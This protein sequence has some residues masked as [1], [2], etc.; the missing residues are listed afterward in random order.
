MPE[1]GDSVLIPIRFTDLSSQR[2]RPVMVI[3]HTAYNRKTADMVVVAMTSNP[4]PDGSRVRWSDAR[5]HVQF[6]QRL[7]ARLA[8]RDEPVDQ[9]LT[10]LERFLVGVAVGMDEIAPLWQAHDVLLVLV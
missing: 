8:G 10:P 7:A 4:G 1:Q 2:R 6:R 5:E 3:S 9:L